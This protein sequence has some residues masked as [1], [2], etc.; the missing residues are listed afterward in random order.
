MT[1]A[2]VSAFA[3][4]PLPSWP[5]AFEPQ[6]AIV[7]FANSAQVCERPA[8]IATVGSPGTELEFAL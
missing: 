8:E 7:P 5:W 2:G 3:V 6:Q 4:V 1:A